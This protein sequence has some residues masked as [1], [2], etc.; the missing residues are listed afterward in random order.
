M[1]TRILVP[2]DENIRLAASTIQSS[3]IVAFPTETVY[4]L[5]ASIFDEQAIQK[6]YTV[7][8]RPSDNPLISHISSLSQVD[9]I[10]EKIPSVFYDLANVFFPGPLTLVVSKKDSVPGIASANLST[11][12]IRMPNHP[13]ALR[14]IDAVGSPLVAP[15]ANVSGKPSPTTA[16]HVLTD[17]EGKISIILDGGP[18]SVGIES[19][20]LDLTVK[21]FVILRPGHITKR[22]LEEAIKEPI[23]FSTVNNGEGIKAPG[24]KYRHYAP[25]ASIYIVSSIMEFDQQ[26]K[27]ISMNN[28]FVLTNIHIS[29]TYEPSQILP[30]KEETLFAAF[31]R[32]DKEHI[33]N[34]VIFL[35]ED[36]KQ[37]MGLLNR[38]EKARQK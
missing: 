2:T 12:G 10:A 32:A 14:L 38:I 16:E 35:D 9:L 6:I 3:D 31:R 23:L 36:T 25:E 19:T 37:N 26:M 1:E 17:L 29:P 11:I 27:T 7:K 30:L 5:G 8:G 24:M 22:Q 4:G 20:V 21:P 34:I 28:T 18:C 33:Q 13:V 15:S